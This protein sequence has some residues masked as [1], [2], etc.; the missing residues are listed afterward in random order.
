MSKTKSEDP[1]D[2]E[3]S[4][5]ENGDWDSDDEKEDDHDDYEDAEEEEEMTHAEHKLNGNKYYQLKDYRGAIGNYTLAIET[6]KMDLDV[7]D[8]ENDMEDTDAAAANNKSKDE[9]KSLLAAYYGNRSAAFQMLL[10]Y[11]EAL[12]DCDSAISYNP[13]FIKAHFRKAKIL[14]TLGR[15]DEASKAYSMGMIH[16]PCNATGMK[17]RRELETVQ[18]RVKMAQ[19]CLADIENVDGKQRSAYA[20]KRDAR[21]AL[22]QIEA[23]LAV[24]PSWNDATLIKIEALSHLGAGRVEEAYAL[25]TKLMRLGLDSPNLIFTRAKCLFRMGSL[26]D[27]IKHLRQILSGDPDNKKAFG[28]L[29]VLRALDKKKKEAD[30]SFKSQQF[31]KAIELYGEAIDLCPTDNDAYRAKLFFNRAVANSKLRNHEECV[32]DCTKA[33]D[34]D[35]DYTKAYLRRASS[36]LMVGGERECEAAIRDYESAQKLMR[37]EEEQRDIAKKIQSAKVQLKRAKRKDMYKILGVS[38]DATEAEIRKAYRKLALKYHPDRQSGNSV[39]EQEKEKAEAKF[40]EI[41]LANEILSDPEK[42]QR[43][44]AGVDEQDVDNPDARPGGGHGRGG[45]HRGGMGG[46]DPEVLFQMFSQHGGGGMGGMH[47][48]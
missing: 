42:K 31:K 30:V 43:Y 15:L 25:T 11:G 13:T 29:K 2:M 24:C 40:R 37:T 4:Y 28:L 47:F 7:L 12:E 6:A 20:N 32:G 5:M 38:K 33:L 17:E 23:V 9:L 22:A 16:D 14:T 10:K 18:K 45:F 19:A 8:R 26:E 21:Q 48:G 34:L 46:I 3:D 44:D 39:T 41:N 1:Q 36:N 27:S 35:K